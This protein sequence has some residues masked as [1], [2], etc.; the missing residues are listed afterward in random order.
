MNL[1][2]V[3]RHEIGSVIEWDSKDASNCDWLARYSD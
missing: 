1:V 3:N 2:G